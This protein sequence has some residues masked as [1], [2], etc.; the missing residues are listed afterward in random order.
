MTA[1]ALSTKAPRSAYAGILVLAFSILLFEIT[2]TRVFA[3]MMWH[4]LTYMVV[5]IAMLGF[6]AAGSLLTARGDGLKEGPASREISRASIAYGFAVMFA[7][8]FVTSVKV[9]S[10]SLW[11]EK[12]NFFALL[13]IYLIITAPFLLG[14]V[15]IGT[16]LT[17]YARDV[18][19][20]Y[21]F[22][23]IGSALGG[24]LS[25]WVLNRFGSAQVVFLAGAAGVLSGFLFGL[26]AGVWQ[27]VKNLPALAVAAAVAVAATGGSDVLRIPASDWTVPFAP[28]KEVKRFEASLLDARIPSATAEVEVSVDL[29]GPPQILGGNFGA[30]DKM[31]VGMR[32]VA[33]DGTAPTMMLKDAGQ[34]ERFR[35]LDDTSAGTAYQAF[36]ARGA[37]EPD[38]LVIGVGGGVDVMT[39]LYHGAK[40]VDAVE[41][42]PAMIDMVTKRYDDYLDGLFRPGAHAW[43]DRV[44]L[45]NSEGRSFMRHRDRKYDVIQMSGVDSFTALSTGAYTLSESYLYTVEAV[46]E[47]YAHLNEGGYVNYSRFILTYPKKPRETLRLAN[48][49]RTALEEL[50]V[51]DPSSQIAVF[52]GHNW[53]STM[54]KKGAFTRQEIDALRAFGELEG[55]RGFAYDPLQERSKPFP[56]N[57]ETRHLAR[58]FFADRLGRLDLDDATRGAVLEPL[59][60]TVAARLVSGDA[61]LSLETALDAL[62]D[63]RGVHEAAIRE[64]LGEAEDGARDNAENFMAL[65]RDFI[66]VLK[67][68]DE[69]RER[70][71]DAYEY[72]VRP[73][74]D[75]A[76]FF[77]NYYRYG[78]LLKKPDE[79]LNQQ[80]HYHYDYP[81]GHMVLLA[82][83]GQIVVIAF[84]LLIVP[85]RRL[86]SQGIRTRGKLRYFAYFAALG[87]GFMFV[88]IAVM[89]KVVIFL[90]HPTYSLSVVLTSLLA[91]AGIGSYLAGRIES[92]TRANFLKLLVAIVASIGIALLGVNHGV[93]ALIGLP[94]AA[95]V[96]FVVVLLAP[97]GLA[98]GMPFPTGIRRLKED[99][100]ELIPWAW[101][102]NGFLSVFSSIFCIVLSMAIGFTKVI[103]IAAAV[104]AVGFLLVPPVRRGRGTAEA[105]AASTSSVGP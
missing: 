5:S 53:A 3:V 81:V 16:A 46:R 91:F 102:I 72:D 60:D 50:G 90:G 17:R 84:V 11:Q 51:A 35:F 42:N 57:T 74:T 96:A 55:F 12:K 71:V 22:D 73:C 93:A 27:T 31:S 92:L 94:F 2:L 78:G 82:S 85:L 15:A 6:G 24:A 77:F 64:A 8:A 1:T 79:A 26:G 69:E 89:Q 75:D 29:D 18:N 9:D 44:H 32:A 70:F 36:A 58:I 33:Q 59:I 87:M 65:Q 30:V 99:A 23:L 104:Y 48:I 105:S 56:A 28:N 37:K 4:H 63:G 67:G 19:R 41:I 100:P 14:G 34:I 7:F 39:A 88:E 80:S 45:H 21:F 43:S 38:V 20:V 76:P 86:K 10:L 49:A 103:L 97:V 47:F 68:T 83:L 66:T 62:G 40:H 101:A 61:D 25:V 13:L 52:V 54:V 95:R 98:L